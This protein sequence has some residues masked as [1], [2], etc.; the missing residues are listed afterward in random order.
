MDGHTFCSTLCIFGGIY[1]KPWIPRGAHPIPSVQLNN[2]VK[3]AAQKFY[4]NVGFYPRVPFCVRRFICNVLKIKSATCISPDIR[5]NFHRF[6]NT[7]RP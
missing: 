5:S 1:V 2:S 3:I 4:K 7:P 6:A